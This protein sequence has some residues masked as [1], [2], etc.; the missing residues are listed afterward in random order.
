MARGAAGRGGLVWGSQ[1]VGSGAARPA[2]DAGALGADD[3]HIAP[4]DANGVA[5]AGVQALYERI[6]QLESENATLKQQLGS[7]DA[8]LIELTALVQTVLV[9]QNQSGSDDLALNQ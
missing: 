8:R 7:T 4:L 2:A 5:L 6:K 1:Q 9:R 3:R